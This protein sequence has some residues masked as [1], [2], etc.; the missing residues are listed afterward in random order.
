[1]GFCIFSVKPNKK[2]LATEPL[3]PALI[4]FVGRKNTLPISKIRIVRYYLKTFTID[5]GSKFSPLSELE[6]DDDDDDLPADPA[7]CTM[8][9]I[10]SGMEKRQLVTSPITG[11]TLSP[12][13]DGI[14]LNRQYIVPIRLSA[15]SFCNKCRPTNP[16]PP[17]TKI[18]MPIFSPSPV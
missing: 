10:S 12:R 16:D 1:M 2:S 3:L 13:R 5:N 9:A 11:L 15:L 8:Q 4:W 7:R 14:F 18:F 6:N 17:V